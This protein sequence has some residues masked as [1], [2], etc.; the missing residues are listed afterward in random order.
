M[1]AETDVYYFRVNSWNAHFESAKSRTVDHKSWGVYPLKQ[2]RGYCRLMA[3]PDGPEAYG[4]FIAMVSIVQG[5][6]KSTRQGYLTDT[7]GI[8]GDPYTLEDIASLTRMPI[9]IISN[10]IPRLIQVG[11]VSACD[12]TGSESEDTTGIPQGYREDTL[13]ALEEKR[14]EEKRRERT[15]PDLPYGEDFAATWKDWRRFRSEISKKLPPTTISRQ[16]AKLAKYKSES[17]AVAVLNQSMEN[18]WT[19]LFD[20]KGRPATSH[21]PGPRL[22]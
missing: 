15:G 20:L 9:A 11:W 22:T 14:R 6:S 19:G 2:G 17:T 21:D 10:A 3:E 12:G 1:T 4:A 18:G 7:G 5:K 8:P 13:G 16:L